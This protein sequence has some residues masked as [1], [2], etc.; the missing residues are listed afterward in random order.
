MSTLGASWET[1]GCAVQQQRVNARTVCDRSVSP[2][3]LS[4]GSGIQR[5]TYTLI[6]T[7]NTQTHTDAVWQ[8]RLHTGYYSLQ[9]LW[10]SADGAVL[11][12]DA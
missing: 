3:R 7:E 8:L 9:S 1:D 5:Q 2:C 11:P 10:S 4:V 12:S 6:H